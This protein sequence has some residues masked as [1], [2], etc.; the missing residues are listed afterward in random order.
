MVTFLDQPLDQQRLSLASRLKIA[1]VVS[2]GEKFMLS[3]PNKSP[4]ALTTV[5]E[6]QLRKGL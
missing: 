1:V 6:N 3:N 5:F 4:S 2:D